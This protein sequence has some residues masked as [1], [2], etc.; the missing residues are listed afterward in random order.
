MV[1]VQIYLVKSLFAL[2]LFREHR[3]LFHTI[4]AERAKVLFL[5]HIGIEIIIAVIPLE[6]VGADNISFSALG[7][8]PFLT[9][10]VVEIAERNFAVG[11][12]RFVEFVGFIYHAVIHTANTPRNIRLPVQ[13]CARVAIGL[14]Q[15]LCGNGLCPL[16]CNELGGLDTID[17]QT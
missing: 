5:A 10:R 11:R 2:A 8:L 1:F 13:A 9:R 16:L 4:N 3:N 17:D 14:L 15:H 12:Y 7:I 6:R